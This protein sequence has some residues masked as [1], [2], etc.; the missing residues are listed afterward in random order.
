MKA[1]KGAYILTS[2][3]CK[4]MTHRAGLHPNLQSKVACPEEGHWWG[5]EGSREM[6]GL[7]GHCQAPGAPPNTKGEGYTPQAAHKYQAKQT[8]RQQQNGALPDLGTR[9]PGPVYKEGPAEPGMLRA[10]HHCSCRWSRAAAHSGPQPSLALSHTPV[11]SGFAGR[12][13][14]T[15]L[16]KCRPGRQGTG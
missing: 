4:I 8:V 12:A 13:V 11:S 2:S 7:A 3:L 10:R 15:V 9:W 1:L 5:R 16:P 6:G 14:L